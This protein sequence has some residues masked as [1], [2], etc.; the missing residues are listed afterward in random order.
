MSSWLSS[1]HWP[2]TY[3]LLIVDT[4]NIFCLYEHLLKSEQFERCCEIL[5]FW[6]L[7]RHC[8]IWWRF[9]GKK[10]HIFVTR[11]SS[12]SIWYTTRHGVSKVKIWPWTCQVWPHVWHKG[13]AQWPAF[14]THFFGIPMLII[15]THNRRFQAYSLRSYVLKCVLLI[16]DVLDLEPWPTFSKL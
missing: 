8:V 13:Q 5:K 3:F 15:L 7:W 16:S 4:S 1:G 9:V 10:Y 14:D 2:L 11:T 6:T 12:R